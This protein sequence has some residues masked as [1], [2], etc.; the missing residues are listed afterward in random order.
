MKEMFLHTQYYSQVVFKNNIRKW[1]KNAKQ[2]K[3]NEFFII[4][5]PIFK[6]LF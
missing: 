6:Q 4:S 5:C 1:D 2:L 3:Q